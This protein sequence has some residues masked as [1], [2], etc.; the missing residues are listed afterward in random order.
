MSRAG[1]GPLA[2]PARE[3]DELELDLLLEALRQRFGFDFR[4]HER[5]AVRR[6]L[7]GV[8]RARGLASLSA[9]QER[10]LHQ[11]GARDAVLAALSPAPATLFEHPAQLRQL[12]RVL[13]AAL[14]GSA[15]PKVWLA[16]CAGAGEAWTLA[17]LL[18]EE[19]L[20]ARTDIFATIASEQLLAQAAQA[21]LPAAQLA[22]CGAD[23]RASGGTA[24]LADYFE[25]VRGR[26]MLRPA[27]RARITW[28]QYNLPTDASFNEFQLI[29][30]R[31]ALADYGPLLR[32]RVLTLFHDSL[33]RFGMLGLDR[34]F[35]PEEALAAH[36]QALYPRRP[37]YKRIA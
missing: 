4:G 19:A 18:H 16:E 31:H 36:Y 6:K 37:W 7:R 32:Q 27:L 17:I 20:G 3:L 24:A 14:H 13:A 1:P 2:S 15:L 30:C 29:L 21:G 23:Y 22:A 11:G 5:A 8:M 33:S 25:V 26:A 9:L 12:R 10:V 35:A 34:C 28:A